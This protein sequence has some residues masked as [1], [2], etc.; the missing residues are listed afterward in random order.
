M[1]TRKR[2]MTPL[3]LC[4]VIGIFVAAAV[5]CAQLVALRSVAGRMEALELALSRADASTSTTVLA[6]A[7]VA[8]RL[9]HKFL[10]EG[11]TPSA[12]QAFRGDCW[13]F[14]VTGALSR[15]CTGP[16]ALAHRRACPVRVNPSA[17]TTHTPLIG[18]RRPAPPLRRTAG[19]LLSTPLHILIG[20]LLHACRCASPAPVSHIAARYSHISPLNCA[21]LVKGV[22]LLVGRAKTWWVGVV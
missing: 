16:A 14:A 5:C 15:S 20:T 8:T 12:D 3:A 18:A 9:P 19:G 4:G 6:Q 1:G 22:M 13:L 21:G 7:P 17:R 10:V 11:L 2:T